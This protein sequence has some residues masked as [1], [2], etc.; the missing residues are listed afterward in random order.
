VLEAARN[1]FQLL[2][3][4]KPEIQTVVA[5]GDTVVVMAREKGRFAATGK[6]YESYWVQLFTF[7]GGKVI[8]IKELADV[9]V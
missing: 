9:G 7:K 3:D 5:Q 8:R 4:Q 1:N 6:E 2:E